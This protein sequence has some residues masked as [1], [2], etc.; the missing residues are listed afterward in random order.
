LSYALDAN[1]LL[2]ASDASSSFNAQARAF[3]E[4]AAQGPEIVFLPWPVAMAYLRIATHPSIF[5]HP[6]T[7][8][9]AMANV[10]ALL[11]RPHVRPL[12]ELEGFW[13]TYRRTTQGDVL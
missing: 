4:R 13:E 12:G 1:V 7:P 5:E 2:Y 3:L 11:T 9:E 8:D 10:E 6:L